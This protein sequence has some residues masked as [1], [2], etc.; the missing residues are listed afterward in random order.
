MADNPDSQIVWHVNDTT[1]FHRYLCIGSKE[2]TYKTEDLNPT[3]DDVEA[4]KRLIENSGGSQVIK[5]ILDYSRNGHAPKKRAA[6]F[7]LATCVKDS[8]ITDV[9]IK[10]SAYQIL[11]DVCPI[12]TD[13]FLFISYCH[14]IIR[15]CHPD[16]TSIGWGRSSRRAIALWYN[17]KD[18][19]LLARQVTKYKQ[20]HSWS[21]KDILRT[22]HVKPKNTGENF[23][24][25]NTVTA[26]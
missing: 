26:Q 6:I 5:D 15:E 13:L 19:M 14:K 8:D 20:R 17:E 21:H 4:M 1:R 16:R 12:P 24:V 9:N 23:N 7:A 2:T 3:R 22:S 11:K 10:Q 25:T 18:P